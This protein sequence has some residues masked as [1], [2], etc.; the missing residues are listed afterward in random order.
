MP[1][2]LNIEESLVKEG[3]ISSPQLQTLKLEQQRSSTTLVEAIHRLKFVPEDVLND[4]L[5]EKLHLKKFS[6]TDFSPPKDLLSLLP[7]EFTWKHKVIPLFREH[8]E[9]AVGLLDPLNAELLEE[10]RFRTGLFIKPYL[11]KEEELNNVLIQYY[12]RRKTKRP[13]SPAVLEELTKEVSEP[14][15]VEAV[16]LLL[17]QAVKVNAS[18]I[19]IEPQEGRMRIHLR[20]DGVLKDISPFEQNIYNAL[21]SRIKIMSNLDIAERRLPQD[22]RF[23]VDLEEGSVDVRVSVI[24]TIQ[25]ESVVL[26][27]L[28]QN[29]KLLTLQ[30]LGMLKDNLDRY[31]RLIQHPSGILLVTGPTGS[32]KTTTLYASLMIL[33]NSEKNIITIEDPVEYQLDF[34][35]QIQVNPKVTLLFSTGLRSILRHDP[36]IIMVGEIRDRETAEIAV[37]AALT[38]HLVLSTLHTNDAASA[39]TRLIDMGIEPFLIASCLNGVVAQRLVRVLCPKCKK[40]M[41]EGS[42]KNLPLSI[43]KGI[44]DEERQSIYQAQGCQDCLHTGFSGR[45]GIFEIMEMGPQIS[46]LT[47][48]KASSEQLIS[49]CRSAGKEFLYDDG[50][51]KVLSGLTSPQELIRILGA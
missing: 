25:G 15:V 22:G 43:P 4:F 1:Q 17:L 12:D 27:L 18:D 47:V 51:K 10:L 31:L 14:T 42:L 36:D 9:L 46:R 38:G 50:W 35:R 21:V 34:C 29:K 32:G 39:I 23:K 5:S 37:Q 7:A 45:L 28:R 33:K 30:E 8:D 49:F 20:V 40:P 19:H 24:P 6:L 13:Q 16:N 2:Q 48:E 26:R 44:S 3:I 11:V 41:D